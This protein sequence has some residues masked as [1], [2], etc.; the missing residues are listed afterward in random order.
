MWFDL[1]PTDLSFIACAP[2][3]LDNEAVINASAARVFEIVSLGE[4]ERV[5]LKGFKSAQWTSAPPYGA[6]S[7]REFTLKLLAPNPPTLARS[8]GGRSAVSASTRLVLDVKE[9]FVVW[10]P[11]RRLSICIEAVSL[12]VVTAMFQDLQMEPMAQGRTRFRW[13]VYYTPSVLTRLVHPLGRAIFGS[14]FS[15]S[16]AA[17][18]RYATGHPGDTEKAQASAAR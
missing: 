17:L 7:T 2:F 15:S 12:P 5:W 4:G 14:I 9:R 16:T 1:K 6:G 3:K 11:G 18:T 10:E 13:Q 8:T